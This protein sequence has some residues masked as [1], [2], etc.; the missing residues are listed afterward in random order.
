MCAGSIG[1]AAGGRHSVALGDDHSVWTA[2]DNGYGQLGNGG[3][4]LPEEVV[5]VGFLMV[6]SPGQCNITL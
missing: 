5:S 2:G 3:P 4:D 1:I 6:I